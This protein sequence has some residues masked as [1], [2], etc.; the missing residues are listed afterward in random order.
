VFSPQ[1][2]P[3]P[4]W[5]F[6]ASTQFNPANPWWDDFPSLNKYVERVQT[7]LQRGT[8]DN[9]VLLYWP[10][11]DLWDDPKGLMRQFTVSSVGFIRD[12]RCGELARAL[13]EAGYAF[14]YIS[15]DQIAKTTA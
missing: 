2:V 15:D 6:Y 10:I 9:R 8:P 11:Y 12:S 4:G 5:L 13:D 14:D 1:N 3:W 7:V